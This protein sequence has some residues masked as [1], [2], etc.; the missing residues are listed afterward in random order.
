MKK[1]WILVAVAVA[2]LVAL[3]AVVVA[4]ARIK[5]S[6]TSIQGAPDLDRLV[7]GVGSDSSG[8]DLATIDPW[9]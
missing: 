2:L 9:T 5:V 4:V 8:L 7:L 1:R 6:H 3:V